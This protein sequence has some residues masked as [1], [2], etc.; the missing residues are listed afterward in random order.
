MTHHVH[1]QLPGRCEWRDS[2]AERAPSRVEQLD[3]LIEFEMAQHD[4]TIKS[5]KRAK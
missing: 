5:F 1:R 4:L 2:K 3:G